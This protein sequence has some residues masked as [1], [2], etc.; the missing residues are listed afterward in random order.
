MEPL[1]V[2]AVAVATVFVTLTLMVWDAAL[3]LKELELPVRQIQIVL[4]THTVTHIM[5][6]P[7][8]WTRMAAL[9]HTFRLLGAAFLSSGQRYQPEK[10]LQSRQSSV[11]LREPG[12]SGTYPASQHCWF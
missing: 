4:Q 5:P 10:S 8:A 11:S 7:F 9:A 2:V 6:N 3:R 12:P 1:L